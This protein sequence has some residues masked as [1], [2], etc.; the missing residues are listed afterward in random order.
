[1]FAVD[2]KNRLAIQDLVAV[3]KRNSANFAVTKIVVRA[4]EELTQNE[5]RG[6]VIV[7]FSFIF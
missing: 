6:S 7:V 3:V 2:A 5:D 1:L 4:G